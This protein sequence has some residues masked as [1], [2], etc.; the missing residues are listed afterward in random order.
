M[1]C[2]YAEKQVCPPCESEPDQLLLIMDVQFLLQGVYQRRDTDDTIKPFDT[3]MSC[4][5]R[6]TAKAQ[7]CE[8]VVLLEHFV[9]QEKNSKT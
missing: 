3:L 4:S 2:R 6:G 5:R 1:S 8:R 7:K 9:A